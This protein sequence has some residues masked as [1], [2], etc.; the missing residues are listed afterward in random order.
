M[1]DFAHVAD[2]YTVTMNALSVSFRRVLF[3]MG[4]GRNISA[5]RPPVRIGRCQASRDRPH[6]H[7]HR[8]R[9]KLKHR[10]QGPARGFCY[11]QAPGEE[12]GRS[13]T[14]TG[15]RKRKAARTNPKP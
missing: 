3:T 7:R 11:T 15:R 10:K 6:P 5:P 4:P 14:G 12:P 9:D 13:S 1:D 2:W 8:P